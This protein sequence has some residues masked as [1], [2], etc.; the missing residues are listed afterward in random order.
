LVSASWGSRAI[1]IGLVEGFVDSQSLGQDRLPGE[2]DDRAAIDAGVAFELSQSAEA[3][4]RIGF[5]VG[6]L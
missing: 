2:I 1:L 3:H 6:Q 4:R 5:G